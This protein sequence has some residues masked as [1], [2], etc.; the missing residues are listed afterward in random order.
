M[1]KRLQS[2][3]LQGLPTEKDA[4]WLFG[5]FKD[6]LGGGLLLETLAEW[7]DAFS[8]LG[9]NDLDVYLEEVGNIASKE[10]EKAVKLAPKFSD[11]DFSVSDGTGSSSDGSLSS[12]PTKQV[13]Q[14]E[15]GIEFSGENQGHTKPHLLR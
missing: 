5:D 7:H 11:S 3:A 13:E 1:V 2:W 6:A 12:T 8:T 14:Q 15:L 9:E 10:G 4:P